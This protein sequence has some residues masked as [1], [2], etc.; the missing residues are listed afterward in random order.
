MSTD[1][2]GN[3]AAEKKNQSIRKSNLTETPPMKIEVLPVRLTP[4][5]VSPIAT[6]RRMQT[7]EE[8]KCA[9]AEMRSKYSPFLANHAPAISQC[10]Q[11]I[12]VK[13]F[14]LNGSERITIPHYGGP[15]GYAVKEYE[16][17]FELEGD[18]SGKAVYICFGGVDYIATVYINGDAV[19]RHEGFF[20]PFEFEISRFVKKGKNTLRITVENDFVYMGSTC[21]LKTGKSFE[22]DKMYAATGLGY[23]DPEDGWHHCPPGMGIYN[24]VR[25][26]VRERIH[27][28]DVYVRPLPEEKKV[29]VWVEIENADY[30]APNLKI[31]L[32]LYGQ[33][34]EETV[35]EDF[36]YCPVFAYA[37]EEDTFRV[38]MNACDVT[39]EKPGIPIKFVNNP[40]TAEHGKNIYKIMMAFEH[41]KL[42]TLENPYLYQIQVKVFSDDQLKDA[43]AQQFG[44]RSFSQDLQSKPKG[45]FYLNGN[46]IKLRGANTMGFEQQDVMNDNIDQ[47][48]DDILL[49]KLCNMNF[50]RLTQR[51]VQDEVY[52][53]CDK[54]GLMTQT[55]LPLFGCMRRTK[56]AEMVRQTEEMIRLVRKHPCNVV[57]S[58]I[59]EPVAEARHKPHRHFEREELEMAFEACDNIVKINCPEC[60]IKHVDGDYDPPT[61]N[62]IQDNHTYTLWYNEHEIE[63]GRLHKGY[64]VD[65]D[66]EWYCGCGE[67][68]AEGLDPVDLMERRYPKE[69]L[70]EP[71]SPVNIVNSQSGLYHIFFYDTPKDIESWVAETQKHQAFVAKEMTECFRRNPNM[72]SSAIHLFI[73]AWPAGWMKTIMDCERTPKPAYFTYR[74][75][76][77]PI[78]VSLRTDRFTYYEGEKISIEAYVCNDTN[79]VNKDCAVVFELYNSGGEIVMSGRTPAILADCDVT[80]AANAEF[81]IPKVD[82]REKFTLKAILLDKAEN[83]LSTNE[84]VV[85][86]FADVELPVNDDVVFVTDIKRGQQTIAGETVTGYKTYMYAR[87]F[88]SMKTGHK[89]VEQFE[90]DDFKFWYDGKVDRISPLTS[91]TFAAEGFTPILMCG[92]KNPDQSVRKDC[93]VAEKLY[94]GKRYI[95]STLDIRCENPVAK[96]FLKE[97]LEL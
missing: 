97:L 71:F 58:Y 57:I 66:K 89:A 85:E 92:N 20:S 68:G 77:E 30:S 1:V 8:L 84:L 50:W 12:D 28:T 38:R 80:Y 75:A 19:G 27:I 93:V 18:C 79:I 35:F 67:Y 69:W 43:K 15:L 51:P 5:S 95:I 48:I 14:I 87:H 54:L 83:V 46:K 63:F 55:D 70:K 60:V 41:V 49:A 90:T 6:V 94:E 72:I 24:Y 4:D 16:S 91:I 29:E 26:E 74:D 76:L 40:L 2:F 53:Y 81:S 3:I 22:G 13:N 39:V 45:M 21:G 17:T 32:S 62:S 86:V 23:D 25:V 37:H 34:F 7:Q 82:D 33:N 11:K 44:M 64:W 65:T 96:R 47:L 78:L 52:E 61:R 9:L 88:V 73:D 10:V 36:E 59:N 56:F 42:W 31:Q